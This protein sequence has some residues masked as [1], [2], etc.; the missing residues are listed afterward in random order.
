MPSPHA[1]LHV[2]T[3]HSD[4]TQ[5]PAEVVRCAAERG[6]SV[7]AVTDH[8]TTGGLAEA[9]AA[10]QKRGVQ[11]VAGVELSA[12]VDGD[13][14]HLLAY[15]IDPEHGELRA[16]L[17]HF[18]DARRRRV[19]AIVDRLQGLGINLSVAA[20]ER[21]AAGAIGRPHVARA[22]VRAGHV[23]SPREAFDRYLEAGAPAYVGKPP[24]PAGEALERVHGAG[25]VGVLAHPGHWTPG[26]RIRT[27]VDAGLDGIEVVHPSHDDTLVSYYRRLAD[28]YG[29]LA[30]GGSDHHGRRRE[31]RLGRIGMSARDWERFRAALA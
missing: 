11:F 6:L 24:V 16:H 14:V 29:L 17:E 8:D 28:G 30:T 1:D 23:G 27:L 5:A 13:E 20:V 25:G 9:R 21:E 31:G 15:G 26:A 18:V 3:H 4:G 22:L 12:T 7:L 2:H 10:A 19:Q